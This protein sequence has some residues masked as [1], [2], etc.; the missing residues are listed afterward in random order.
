M[1]SCVCCVSPIPESQRVCSMCYGDPHYG[2]DGY[3]ME[4]LEEEYRR[5]VEEEERERH[6]DEMEQ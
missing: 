3:Y 1:N 2:K 5:M 6:F 4:Y